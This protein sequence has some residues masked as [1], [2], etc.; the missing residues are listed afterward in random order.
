MKLVGIRLPVDAIAVLAAEPG[1][2][3]L[4][5]LQGRTPR[6]ELGG[7]VRHRQGH[8]VPGIGELV[9]GSQRE[10]RRDVLVDKMVE[11]GLNPEDYWW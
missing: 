2:V 9:G 3:R 5:E 8:L 11:F 1:G 4:H 6:P 7:I 10:E